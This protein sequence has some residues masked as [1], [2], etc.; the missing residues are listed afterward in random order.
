M[1]I[2]GGGAARQQQFRHRH[3]DAE[4]ERFRRQPRPD[5]IERLQPR[6][7]LAVQRRRQ[8]PRQRLVEM[9]VG[10][11]QPRQHHMVAG[12][13]ERRRGRRLAAL[14]HQFDDPAVLDDDAAFR[15]VG[16]N[17]QRVLDPDRL[18]LVHGLRHLRDMRCMNS[19]RCTAT[20]NSR[21]SRELPIRPKLASVL[22]D[23]S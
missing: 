6:K 21:T 19:V 10:V 23:T 15:A 13:E 3:G 16:Q 8:R 2:G 12:L 4:V 11:D 14:G 5:R 9:M 1:M 22:Q 18:C 7:Q 17:G 20:C